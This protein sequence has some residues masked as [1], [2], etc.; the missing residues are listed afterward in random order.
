[1]S[2]SSDLGTVRSMCS[3]WLLN[4]IR[5]DVVVSS[6]NNK[7]KVDQSAAEISWFCCWLLLSLKTAIN[8]E[9]TTDRAV[10]WGGIIEDVTTC[11]RVNSVRLKAA[12]RS[13]SMC[14]KIVKL[15]VT[16]SRIT[17]PI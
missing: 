12:K 1:L 14:Q 2:S 8:R 3:E 9:T 5:V 11:E 13:I 4:V 6:N 10:R 16:V 17:S 15:S 7:Q